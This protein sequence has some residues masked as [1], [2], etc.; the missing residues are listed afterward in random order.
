MPSLRVVA[1]RRHRTRRGAARGLATRVAGVDAWSWEELEAYVAELYRRDGCTKVFLTLHGLRGSTGP[2]RRRASGSKGKCSDGGVGARGGDRWGVNL[3]IR[4]RRGRGW[5]AAA[6]CWR[7][8][9]DH[10]P[11]DGPA[12]V[13]RKYVAAV[14]VVHRASSA[15]TV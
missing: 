11:Q 13:G 4:R 15:S 5:C 2:G 10:P 3:R 7:C 1:G 14:H 6:L 8:G 9:Q 12:L